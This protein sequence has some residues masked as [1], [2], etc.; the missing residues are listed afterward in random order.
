MNKNLMTVSA[1]VFLVLLA[2][3]ALSGATVEGDVVSPAFAPF[4]RVS[5]HLLVLDDNTSG[6]PLLPS[7]Y[8][9]ESTG[10]HRIQICEGLGRPNPEHLRCTNHLSQAAGSVVDLL[11]IYR[12]GDFGGLFRRVTLTRGD[13]DYVVTFS[14]IDGRGR[15]IPGT[16]SRPVTHR[17]TVGESE[18]NPTRYKFDI[19]DV[20]PKDGIGSFFLPFELVV[21]GSIVESSSSPVTQS[22]RILG[23]S[24]LN[25]RGELRT[26]IATGSQPFASVQGITEGFNYARLGTNILLFTQSW[27]EG[28]R[29]GH[30]ERE[31]DFSDTVRIDVRADG[32]VVVLP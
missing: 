14:L 1:V 25:V 19:N 17:F 12:T 18:N 7:V 22:V 4:F 21:D 31:T 16:E 9:F 2:P 5:D 23:G 24:S 32:T 30:R 27:P 20:S 10:S 28:T 6:Q 11:P 13:W 26:Q 3:M 8:F 29:V 15:L